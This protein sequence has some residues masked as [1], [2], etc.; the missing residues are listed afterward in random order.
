MLDRAACKGNSTLPRL[1]DVAGGMVAPSR[2]WRQ[3]QSEARSNH[4]LRTHRGHAMIRKLGL[5][6]QHNNK[7]PDRTILT[8][9]SM[10]QQLAQVKSIPQ[11]CLL[12][13]PSSA[14]PWRWGLDSGRDFLTLAAGMTKDGQGSTHL[15]QLKS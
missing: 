7:P 15:T 2:R 3:H 14:K 1:V 6:H 9:G 8:S 5:G 11:F 10:A 13:A 12:P 4:R